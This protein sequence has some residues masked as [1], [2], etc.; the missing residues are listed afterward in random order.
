MIKHIIVYTFFFKNNFQKFLK[1]FKIQL[2]IK[3]T[4]I[5]LLK[6]IVTNKKI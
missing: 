2:L 3:K 1:Y 5:Y 6:C 4:F